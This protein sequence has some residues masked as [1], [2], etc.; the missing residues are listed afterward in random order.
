MA[1]HIEARI[2]GV[3]LTQTLGVKDNE[4]MPLGQYLIRET[5]RFEG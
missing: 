3:D 4:R 1:L 5:T 2:S